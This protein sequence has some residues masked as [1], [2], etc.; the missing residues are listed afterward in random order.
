MDNQ[1][2]MASSKNK[3]LS[4]TKKCTGSFPSWLHVLVATR[5][6]LSSNHILRL[7]MFENARGKTSE[8]MPRR[9]TFPSLTNRPNPAANGRL[10]L[11][12]QNCTCCHG[13]KWTHLA[14]KETASEPRTVVT[15]AKKILLGCLQRVPMTLKS[16][17]HC[18][19]ASVSPSYIWKPGTNWTR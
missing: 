13:T 12:K 2:N 7:R 18:A 4:D 10:N 5:M 1:W 15:R 14:V 19:W 3:S 6:P 17:V 8:K 11:S 9:L 16:Q